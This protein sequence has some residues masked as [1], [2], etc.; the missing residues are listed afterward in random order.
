MLPEEPFQELI[1]RVRAGDQDAADEQAQMLK[2]LVLRSARF[3]MRRRADYHRIRSRLGDSDVCQSVLKNLFV[4]L[5]RGLFEL[6]QPEQLQR[7]LRTMCRLKIATE[8]RRLSAI[9]REVM[10]DGAP[11]DVA[12]SGP[13]PEKPVDDHDLAE[14]VVKNFSDEE[15]EILQRR[16]DGQAWSQIAAEMGVSADALRVR[17]NRALERIRNLPS[18]RGLLSG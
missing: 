3:E 2:P 9:L 11:P 15:L 8:G 18:L 6:D 16:L 1:V 17:L 13:S 7:L 5:R 14:V 4:G 12:D 10:D